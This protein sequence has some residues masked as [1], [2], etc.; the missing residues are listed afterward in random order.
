MPCWENWHLLHL[1]QPDNVRE[2]CNSSP[3]SPIADCH[4]ELPDHWVAMLAPGSCRS[5]LAYLTAW[6]TTTAWQAIAVAICY[7]DATLLQ[8][9]IVLSQPERYTPTS[10]QT[11]LIMWAI[12]LSAVLMNL[13]T[14]RALARFEGLVLIIH[15]TGFFGILIP[16]VYLAPHNDAA[17]VFTAFLNQGGWPDHGLSFLVGLPSGAAS[18]IGADCAVHLS[19]EVSQYCVQDSVFLNNAD[20]RTCRY[21][22][23]PSWYRERSY[24]PSLLMEC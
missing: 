10:W 12:S 3:S 19:E 1:Q 14:A 2:Y 11:V 24:T 13:T 23:L 22:P 4:L 6:L 7:L 8:G 16:M 9:M 15:L 17:T 20:S 18:L 21:S 5:F